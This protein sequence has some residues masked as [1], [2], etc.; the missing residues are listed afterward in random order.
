MQRINIYSLFFYTIAARQKN[1][2]IPLPQSL[3]FHALLPVTKPSCMLSPSPSR[4]AT[5]AMICSLAVITRRDSR[6][7][8]PSCRHHVP[9]QPP[10]CKKTSGRHRP[11]APHPFMGG[12]SH[13]PTMRRLDV[14]YYA[15][16]PPRIQYRRRLAQNFVDRGP[17]NFRFSRFLST[18]D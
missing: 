9:Q 4:A 7:D 15:R 17:T 14:V 12:A 1:D 2:R 6:H 10:L 8:M 18:A 5:A 11:P 13:A 16:A 3:P